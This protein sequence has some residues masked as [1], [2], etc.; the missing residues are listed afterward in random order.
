MRIIFC[1]GNCNYSVLDITSGDSQIL[2]RFV[3]RL[4][5]ID[6]LSE[7]PNFYHMYVSSRDV[8]R[9]YRFVNRLPVLVFRE[10]IIEFISFTILPQIKLHYDDKQ[11]Q[12]TSNHEIVC[13]NRMLRRPF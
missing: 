1:K 2:L 13:S 8:K 7:G 11:C 4:R 3:I 12:E 10:T 6:K 9:C 5:G